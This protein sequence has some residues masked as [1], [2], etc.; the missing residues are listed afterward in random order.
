MDLR[1][2][3]Y[4]MHIHN[5]LAA[6]I[7]AGALTVGLACGG[8][9]IHN[10]NQGSPPPPPG[11]TAPLSPNYEDESAV[12]EL[13][14]GLADSSEP[15]LQ[16]LSEYEE[17]LNRG[18]DEMMFF[19][20][21]PQAPEAAVIQATQTAETLKE[22]DKQGITPL[23]I[24]EPEGLDLRNV[25]ASIFDAY[26]QALKDA[27]VDKESIGMWALFPEPNIP[28]WSVEQDRGNTNPEIFRANF[29]AA[30]ESLKRVFPEA[31]TV[32]LLNAA[33]WQSHDVDYAQGPSYD[34]DVLLQYARGI[35]EG[36]V[37]I[38]C[39]QG[40]PWIP[41]DFNPNGGFLD[42]EL[43]IAL[44]EELGV[45]EVRLNTGTFSQMQGVEI[46]PEQRTEIWNRILDQI[47]QVSETGFKVTVD[48]FAEQKFWAGEDTDWSYNGRPEDRQLLKDIAAAAAEAGISLTIF[49]QPPPE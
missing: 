49:D 8:G 44:A 9:Y 17:R 15:Q 19:R 30:A 43:A 39:L 23:I 38:A 33:T 34:P 12:P 6:S 42:A 24:F 4:E 11:H 3:R 13:H 32:M 29:T 10:Q 41:A 36:L 22:Y 5:G 35:P 1:V 2:G 25:D 26:F 16:L 40:F 31:Q 7:A 37:D 48:L 46:S 21:I 47:R 20:D 14:P 45:E 27:G 18:F 28:E